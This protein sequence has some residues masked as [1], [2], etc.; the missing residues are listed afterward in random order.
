MKDIFYGRFHIEQATALLYFQ[1]KGVTQKLLHSL[2]YKGRE[3][4]GSFLGAWLGAELASAPSY[5]EVEMVLPVPLHK[6]RLRKR[7]YNQVEKFG[8]ELA[9]ALQVPYRDDILLK[10]S[11][12]NS[13]VFKNRLMRSDRDSVFQ[14]KDAA[15]IAGMHLLLVDDI[16]TTGATIESCAQQLFTAPNIK[17]SVATMAM[18]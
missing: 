13:Q 15:T 9:A 16:V 3:E 12:S 8:R 1:K 11:K 7:G 4:I 2:K 14:L 5:K 18:A 10:V 17:L 6:Q